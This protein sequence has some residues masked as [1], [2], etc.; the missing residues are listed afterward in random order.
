MRIVDPDTSIECPAGTVGEIWVHGDNV[1]AGY[2]QKPQET[3]RTFGAT[4]VGPSAGT[5]EGPWLRTGDLGFFSDGEMFIVGRIK[6]LLIV[7]GRNHSPDDIEATIQEITRGRCVAIAV[8]DDDGVETLVTIVELKVGEGSEEAATHIMSVR[9]EITSAI[10]KSHGLSVADLVLV[11]PHSIPLTTS[12]KVRRR[13]CLQRYLRDDFTRLEGPTRRREKRVV[14]DTGASAGADPGLTR[15][16]RMLHQQQ[17]DLLVGLVCSQVATVLGRH[18]PDDID[19][20]CAF[21]DLGFDSVKATELLDRLKTATELAL[22]PTLAF[23]YPTPDELAAHL[24]Q[25][26]TGSVAAAPQVGSRVG[27]D[28]PLA[29]VGMACRFPGGVDSAAALW[30]LVA[31][32]TEG[33]GGFPS[34]RG[35]NLSDLFD[36]DPDAVGKTYTRAGA[37]L[38]DVAGFDAEFFGISAREAQVMDPQQRMLLEVC[39]EALETAQIDPAALVGSDT[40]VFVGTWSQ[41]YGAGGSDTSEG[42]TLTGLATSVA[43]GRVAY[44]LGLQGPAITV[45]TACSS[46]LVAIH[47]ACQ[48]LRNGE[49]ALALAGGVTVMTTPGVFTEFARQ[50]GLAVDGRCKAFSANADGTGWGEGAAVLV[51]ERLSDAHR[52]NHPLLAVIAGSAI[53]QDGASNGLTAPNG[54]AQQRVITQAVANAGIGLDQVDV[55]EA[56]GTG[57]TL[58]DPI[59]AG[60]LIATYGAARSAERPLWLGSIKSNIG[61]TQA[62]SGVAGMIKM[63]AALNHDSL[64]PTLNVDHPSPHIDMSAGTVRLLTEPVPWPVTDHPR[65]AAVSSFGISGTNAHLILQQAPTAASSTSPAKE[66]VSA[67]PAEPTLPLRLWPIS[68]RSQQ[69]LTAQAGRLHQHLISHPGLDLTDLAY[70]LATTRSHHLYRAT[71]VESGAADN[72]R[73]DLLQALHALSVG[74]P[75]RCLTQHHRL[76]H[77]TGKTVFVF[78]GQGAQYPGMG[79]DLYQHEP[80][81]ARTLDQVCAALDNHL[82][83]PLRDVLFAQPPST[84]AELLHQTAYAQP[85]LFAVGAA[86]HAL[87]VGV[88]ITPDHLLGHSIGE[89][90]A[91]YVAGVLSLSDAAVLVTARGRLMQ[92]CPAGAMIAV[93]A[94]ERDVLAM[95]QDHPQT[96]IAAI[97][98]PASVVVSGHPDELDRIREH[99]VPR[100]LKVTPL[101]VSHAFHSAYM[102]PALPEFEATAAGLTFMPPTVPVLSNLTGRIATTD[103]LTSSNYWTRQLREPVRFHDSVV[104]LLAQGQHTFVE[105]SPHPV[106]APAIVDTMAGA[107][108]RAQSVVITTLHRDRPDRDAVATAI[109]QL[110]NHGHSPSWQT[111]YPHAGTTALPT[112][113]FQH[114]SYWVAPTAATEVGDPATGVLWQAVEDDAVDTVAKVLGLSDAESIA[115]LGPVVRAL[116]EWRRD[117]NVRSVVNKLRY[118]VGWRSVRP[119]TFPLTRQRWLVLAA[120]EQC[121]DE[122]VAG[123]SAR[124]AGD[125]EVLIVDL[126][127][128][129]RDSLSAYLSSMARRIHCD[130]IV[131]FMATDERPHSAYPGIATGVISTLLV[132][133]AHCDSGVDVPLWVITKGGVSV[134]GDD[135]PPSPSQ[136]AIWG[137]GQSICLEHPDQWGGLIDLPASASSRDFEQLHTILTCPQ[138]EDQLAIRPQGVS[139]R[140][141]YEAPL[142]EQPVRDWRTSGTALVTGATGRLGKHIVQWLAEAGASHLLLLSRNAGENPQAAELENELHAAGIATTLASVDVTDPAALAAVIAKTRSEHGPIR[143]VVHAAA[144]IGWRTVSETTAEEFSKSYAAK[145]VGGDNLVKLLEDEPPETFIL[146]SS[147][148]GIW[149]GARQGCYAAANAHVD[150]LAAQLRAKG[151]TA[152]SAAFGLWADETEGAHEILDTFHILGINPI[153]SETAFAALRQSLDADDALI[154]IADISW[155]RFLPAFTARRSHPLLSE[156]AAS[157]SASSAAAADSGT[158]TASSQELRARLASQTAEQQR[159]TLTTLVK[160]ATATVLAHPDPAALDPDRPFKDLGFDSLAALKLRN[161]L[162]QQAGLTLPATLALDHPTPAALATHL[163]D[164]LTD[165]A[166]IGAPAAQ[167]STRGDEPVDNRL[168]HL[169]QAAF[170]ALRAVHGALIQVT[171]IYDRAVNLDG[172]RRFHRNLGHGL[173]GRRIERSPVPFARDRWVL[174]PAS[175]DIDIAAAPRGRADVSAWADERAR[176]PIDPERGPGWHLGVLPLEDGGT[177]VSLVASHTVVDA[178]GC[179]QAI[180]DAAEGRTRDLGYPPAGSRTRRRALRE[181]LR[182]TAEDLPEIAQALSAVARRARRDRKELTSSVKAAPPSP[183]AA[184]GDQVVEVPALTAYID[185]ADWDACAKRLGASSNSLVAGVACR[186]A[187]RAGRVQDDGTVTLRFLVSLRTDDDTRGNALT[188]IDVAVDP[189]HAATDLGEIHSKITQAILEAMENSDDEFLAPLPLAAMTPKWVAR[190]LARMAAGG[191]ILPVT[192]S[193][194]GDLAPVA[195]RPDGTDAR[196]AYMRPLEPDIK[197]STLEGMGGQLFLG[198]G[199]ASGKMSIRISAYLLGQPNT[200]SELQEIVSRTLAEFDLNAEIDSVGGESSATDGMWEYL[201][202]DMSATSPDGWRKLYDSISSRLEDVG[203]AEASFFLNYGY[204]PID[205]YNESSEEIAAG[206]F[207]PSS[208]R[209]VQELIGSV[210]LTGSTIVD[211]GCGRGG[212][213]ALMSERFGGQVIGIDMSPQAIAFCRKVHPGVHFEVGDALELPLSDNCCDAVVNLESSH[214][215]SDRDAFLDE[216]NRICRP[217]GWFLYSDALGL[218]DWMKVRDKLKVLGFEVVTDRDISANVIAS[219]DQ[220]GDSAGQVFGDQGTRMANF[221][222]LPGS[223]VYTKLHAGALGYR[224][225][226]SRLRVDQE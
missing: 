125:L 133:Q 162:N 150:A 121:D 167:I 109:A 1:A 153:E 136:S 29:V 142:P 17:H 172:L 86:M 187:V 151:C 44:A 155:D 73:D 129:D 88:G 203:V 182:Q 105:L 91:A 48:S 185:L 20:E 71:V 15:R 46:S 36:P 181:D 145:A 131:S 4:L 34:D 81:F 214:S 93:Q 216:V 132:A 64:P 207:N 32:G 8:P 87:F 225:I 94:S 123:L 208:I 67:S 60:A 154:T 12:G 223:D 54:P 39:W 16:V 78:P 62:A 56:H 13:D 179:G 177:A 18:S 126:D 191:D 160:T 218:E 33:L 53:N 9:R 69:A 124:Y 103:Q 30:D 212:T 199:R 45:D 50:R 186:L 35:W 47:L 196:Y 168:A 76:S 65:T 104:H 220:A 205:S 213:A 99:H 204:V 84:S 27:L 137:L 116:R 194:V 130:G 101:V 112:Y 7:Y 115:S 80:T 184:G 197:R 221:L 202:E 63:I 134:S 21:Q 42:Y 141:I 114:R 10:S 226:R 219:R 128:F 175:E 140:R 24:G 183:R 158:S 164:L 89:L 26:M 85:A 210:D 2:W 59:E 211:I 152:L 138:S 14:D 22:P 209:L 38:A 163:T 147:A 206:T 117:L 68:A 61:H 113:P 106:L 49:S 188:S 92:A 110:H 23:D 143:T 97:N 192:C 166:A 74:Q 190:R 173:L 149:G 95:L 96:T 139:A 90:T 157:I 107:A 161:A 159:Q 82:E 120:P 176:L 108:E 11:P 171:W 127:K 57:T 201:E 37:F 198:S 79:L 70:S 148:A 178:I 170:L 119:S 6:D 156:L 180:A 25:L 72:P 195:N 28:E 189:T 40:G 174:S 41:P 5:P 146:F 52:N 122:W 217:G 118:R 43:S 102:D 135:A 100:G 77:Q 55:V 215:Y 222:G 169:D 200:K 224:I 193:N 75:H 83:V 144:D 31:S 98:G 51:L 3:E 165:T 58:G 66:P 111:R 19:P